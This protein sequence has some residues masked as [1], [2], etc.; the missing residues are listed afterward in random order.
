MIRPCDAGEGLIYARVRRSPPPVSAQAAQG[1]AAE[2][3]RAHGGPAHATLCF[4]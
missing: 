1:A 4:Y 2:A 3:R